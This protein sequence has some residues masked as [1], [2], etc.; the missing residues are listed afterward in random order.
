[1]RRSHLILAVAVLAL[2]AW[3]LTARTRPGPQY[4]METAAIDR[5]DIVRV[6]STSGSVSAL[7]TVD[8]GTQL[9]GQIQ[10]LLVDYNT[11]VT[12]GQLIARIDPK[13][14]EMRTRQAEADL[15]VAEANIAIQRAGISRAEANLRHAQQEFDR[16]KPL[17]AKGSV[18]ESS[19]DSARADL[20]TARAE[21]EMAHAELR[22][23]E[24][25]RQQREAVLASARID[26]ERT[27]IYSPISGVV[28]ERSVAAGQTVA[29]SLSSPV[30][31]RIAQDLHALQ[32][33]A[34]VD[35]A[36]IG[37]VET[38]N[39]VTFSV[40]AYPDRVF[41]GEVKQ[42]R[43]AP[44]REQNVV[45]YTVIIGADNPDGK[46]LPGMTAN[47]DILT[48]KREGVLRIANDALR[49]RPVEE[50]LPAEARTPHVPGEAW[51]VTPPYHFTRHLLH[52][53]ISDER[54]TEI[55]GGDLQQGA[56][57]V[58]RMRAVSTARESMP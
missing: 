42:V 46:L 58:T 41:N 29:A 8:V 38:G 30:L 51:T 10:D 45:T 57:V 7:V 23:A 3:W 36:D 32:I 35:E 19:L 24:A 5:G 25:T 4:T 27:N 39:P 26:L 14:F 40:D 16:Q 47:V 34:A 17:A 56:E 37:F 18:S 48:G 53:G 52:L 33:E 2:A 15:K 6:V 54:H 50:L 43:L 28:I 49:F 22:N 55:L 1:M 11:P 21:L 44:V 31:F 12:A 13:T 9:S 20:D